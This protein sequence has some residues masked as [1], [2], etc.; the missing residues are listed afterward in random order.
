M[1][2]RLVSAF[3][4]PASPAGGLD[5]S[6]GALDSGADGPAWAPPVP[7]DAAPAPRARRAARTLEPASVAVLAP[8]ATARALGAVLALGAAGGGSGA[9]LLAC[10]GGAGEGLPGGPAAPVSRGARRLA[11]SLRTRGFEVRAAGRLAEVRLPD[12]EDDALG[13]LRRA[14]R[15]ATAAGAAT[16]VVLGRARSAAW[17]GVLATRDLVVLHGGD[18][19]VVS[20]ATAQLASIGAHVRPIEHLPSRPALALARSGLTPWGAT[21]PIRAVLAVTG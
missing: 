8:D 9:A 11:A 7:G 15:A 12:D 1:W 5:G 19:T 18:S 3:I 17:D 4:R 2:S 6:L 13:A 10:W 14:E 16:V 21:G 20:L